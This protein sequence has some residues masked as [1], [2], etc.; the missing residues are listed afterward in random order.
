MKRE[1]MSDALLLYYNQEQAKEWIQ[2]QLL[3]KPII[4]KNKKKKKKLNKNDVIM[5]E[6]SWFVYYILAEQG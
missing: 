5:A 1:K 6:Y 3:S 4:E 2:N